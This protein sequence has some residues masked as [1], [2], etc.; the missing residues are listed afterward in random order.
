MYNNNTICTYIFDALQD[1]IPKF[2]TSYDPKLSINTGCSLSE[3]EP[4]GFIQI[5]LPH[6]F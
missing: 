2:P 4:S 6:N 1:D 3:R 5:H